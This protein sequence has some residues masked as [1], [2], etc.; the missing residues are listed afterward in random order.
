[1]QK[2]TACLLLEQKV[3]FSQ[4]SEMHFMHPTTSLK[5]MM[6]YIYYWVQVRFTCPPTSIYLHQQNKYKI[7]VIAIGKNCHG[8]WKYSYFV[9]Q[10]NLY[11]FLVH[12]EIMYFRVCFVFRCENIYEGSFW[13][14]KLHDISINYLQNYCIKG[15]NALCLVY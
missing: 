7:Y 3:K 14:V 2:K 8:D 4:S 13:L 11:F 10:S 6:I 1:M 15:L 9:L 12:K 5:T